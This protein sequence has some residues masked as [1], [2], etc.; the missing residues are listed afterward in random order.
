M[1]EEG[2]IELCDV[3]GQNRRRVYAQRH[4][5]IFSIAQNQD[6]LFWTRWNDSSVMQMPKQNNAN[7][8]TLYTQV[9]YVSDLLMVDSTRQGSRNRCAF[10][11][12]G[13]K[14]LCLVRPGKLP[15]TTDTECTCPTHYTMRDGVCHLPENFLLYSQRNALYRLT[16]STRDCPDSPLPISGEFIRCT[17]PNF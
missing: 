5:K 16:T 6:Y 11:N 12:G 10:N 3:N 14:Y 9:G 4:E 8:R 7:R 17:L 13:C 15:L 1:N 2:I